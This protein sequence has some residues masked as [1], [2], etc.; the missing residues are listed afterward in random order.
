MLDIWSKIYLFFV[1]W[2]AIVE[3]AENALVFTQFNW[4][5][6]I[7]IKDSTIPFFKTN[8]FVFVTIKYAKLLTHSPIISS[9]FS[10]D[11]YTNHSIM[12]SSTTFILT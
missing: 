10:N 5:P 4:C 1:Q 8:S 3:S 2:A 11:P 7:N 6:V 12:L 9:S